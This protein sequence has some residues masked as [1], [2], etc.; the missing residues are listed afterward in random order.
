MKKKELK[1]GPFVFLCIILLLIGYWTQLNLEFWLTFYKGQTVE[2]P[3]LL[4]LLIT[5]ILRKVS[6]LGN[7]ISEIIKLV[8]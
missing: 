7:A 1:P 6:L 8:I 2:V 3:Y 5:V 4:A